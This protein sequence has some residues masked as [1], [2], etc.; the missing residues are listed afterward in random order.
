MSP[1]SK[2]LNHLFREAKKFGDKASKDFDE[3]DIHEMRVAVKKIKAAFHFLQFCDPDLKD[4][5]LK[6]LKKIFGEAGELRE[7]QLLTEAI[8]KFRGLK[9]KDDKES[10]LDFLKE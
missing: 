10:L 9:N 7:L 1:L 8:Q 2:Y 5:E 4:D 3:D 6:K